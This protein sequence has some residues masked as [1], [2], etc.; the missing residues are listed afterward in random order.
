MPEAKAVRSLC[1]LLKKLLKQC[2]ADIKR[3]ERTIASLETQIER[4]KG[5][6][7]PNTALIRELE[8]RLDAAEQQLKTDQSQCQAIR[9]EVSASCGP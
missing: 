8:K 1:A 2:D 6:S 7:D 5:K 4:L 3:G 9:E